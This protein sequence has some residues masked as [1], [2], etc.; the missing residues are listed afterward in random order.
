MKHGIDADA[1]SGERVVQLELER[2]VPNRL[3]PRKRF[4]QGICAWVEL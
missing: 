2:I 4:G 3:Q 1:E